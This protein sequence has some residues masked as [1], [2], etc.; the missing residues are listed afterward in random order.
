MVCGGGRAR[1]G[2]LS[3]GS[4]GGTEV[5]LLFRVIDNE[6]EE[7]VVLINQVN[8]DSI[9]LGKTTNVQ[10]IVVGSHSP[11]SLKHRSLPLIIDNLFIVSSALPRF[12]YSHRV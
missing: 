6:W 3:S 12:P 8:S 10:T 1:R 9:T 4:S 11:F 7:G 2:F 5:V